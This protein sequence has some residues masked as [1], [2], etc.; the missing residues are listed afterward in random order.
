MRPG[1]STLQGNERA[2]SADVPCRQCAFQRHGI[3]SPR[4]CDKEPD[5]TMRVEVRRTWVQRST[6]ARA[7]WLTSA[8]RNYVIVSKFDPR[9]ASPEHVTFA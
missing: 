4:R 8:D 2:C 6:I 1:I 5:I 7:P 9:I 3:A